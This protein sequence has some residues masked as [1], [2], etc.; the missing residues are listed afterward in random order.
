MSLKQYIQEKRNSQILREMSE[1]DI[2]NFY[3]V[4][5]VTDVSEEIDVLFETNVKGMMLQGKGGL[6]P[7]DIIYIGKDEN[8]A[9]EIAQQVMSHV[10]QSGDDSLRREI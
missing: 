6:N 10:Q 2:G 3:V 9:K 8:K 5:K 7:E 1:D 4:T